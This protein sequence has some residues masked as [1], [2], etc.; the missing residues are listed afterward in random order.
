MPATAANRTAQANLDALGLTLPAAGI[1]GFPFAPHTAWNGLVLVSGQIPIEDGDVRHVGKVG[2]DIDF[3]AARAA[4]RLCALHV[5]ARLRD[6]CDGD[7]ER[8]ERVLRIGGYVNAV[9]EFTE[10][11]QV[12]N[13]ASELVNA[14]FG[15]R[16]R[17]ARAAI[18]VGSLPLGV[19]V[20][21][22]AIA[23]IRA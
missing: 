11:S 8:V 21:V 16:G 9:P 12:I 19:A 17:H 10:Q 7:L 15:E 1:A 13:A 5:I 18:G 14:V 3:E 23:A 22:D 4:A 20:E 6:A 2:R